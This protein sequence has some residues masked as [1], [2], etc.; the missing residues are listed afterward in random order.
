MFKVM[1]VEDEPPIARTIK[2]ALEKADTDFKVEKCCINGRMAVETLLKEDYDIVITDIKMPVM[3]GI[4]LA[5]WISENKPD[6]M[7]IILSGYS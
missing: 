3:T 1:I 4:E 6:T 7:V 5:G 2:A